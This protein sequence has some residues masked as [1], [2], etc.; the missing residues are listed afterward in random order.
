M[1]HTRRVWLQV[2]LC[3]IL[4]LTVGLA[5]LV[6]AALDRAAG[7]TLGPVQEI[8][9]L[10][11]RLPADWSVESHVTSGGTLIGAQAPQEAPPARVIQVHHL[12]PG[13]HKVI[14]KLFLRV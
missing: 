8:G 11:L 12:A 14:Y 5:A 7:V 4:V 6:S 1:S 13:S 2:V 3:V 9:T 10:R